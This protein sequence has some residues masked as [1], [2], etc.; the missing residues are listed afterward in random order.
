MPSIR[1]GL[2]RKLLEYVVQSALLFVSG[3]QMPFAVQFGSGCST[4]PTSTSLTPLPRTVMAAPSYAPISVGSI[5]S[6]ARLP[7]RLKSHPEA[8]SN[9]IASTLRCIAVGQEYVPVGSYGL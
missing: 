1:D 3:A 7:L 4:P 2:H 9:G 5:S 6:S 8:G